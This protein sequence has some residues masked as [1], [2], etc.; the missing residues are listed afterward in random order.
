[1]TNSIC[2]AGAAHT[3][4]T[5]QNACGNDFAKAVQQQSHTKSGTPAQGCGGKAETGKAAQSQRAQNQTPV[6][7]PRSGNTCGSAKPQPPVPAQPKACPMPPAPPATTIQAKAC[8]PQPAPK[9]QTTATTDTTSPTS[10]TKGN[11]VASGIN[12]TA[13]DDTLQGTDG[14]DT[15]NGL[16]GDDDIYGGAGNDTING[17]AGNDFIAGMCGDDT[18]NAGAGD[19]WIVSCAGN[20]T[21]NGGAGWDTVQYLGNEGDYTVTEGTEFTSVYN[22]TTKTTDKL[23]NIENIVFADSADAGITDPITGTDGDDALCG[24]DGND[25]ID[26]GN[27]NDWVNAGSGDDTING[28]DG[29][30]VIYGGAGNDTIDG[31]T[32][33][34]AIAGQCGNDTI[35]GGAGKDWIDGGGGNDTIDGGDDSDT[36]I[37]GAGDDIIRGGKGSDTIDGGAGNDTVYL[38]GMETDYRITKSGNETYVTDLRSGD[39]DTLVNIENIKYDQAQVTHN[40]TLDGKSIN[41]DGKYRIDVDGGTT[42]KITNL[43]NNQTTRI[44]GDPHVDVNN[45]GSNDFNFKENMTFQLADGTKITVATVDGAGKEIKD[46][47]GNTASVSVTKTL[48]ITNNDSAIIVTNVNGTPNIVQATGGAGIDHATNDGAIIVKESNGQ[49]VTPDGAKVDQAA[50]N[51]A[52]AKFDLDKAFAT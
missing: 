49:W 37:G 40:W 5:S 1:M 41:L 11:C 38:E 34:D 23:V 14:D 17:G 30:D 43:A 50:I 44:W 33:D 32:G 3:A 51:A 28:T 4:R 25:T 13:S 6:S 48:T 19:D 7:E 52:E 18:I 15:I 16:C 45:D 27:G 2:S 42:W 20:D 24:T 29:D 10:A 22:K 31:G 36:I 46:A 47:N 26:A 39:V 12:G 9:P 8:Q 35:N 21:I